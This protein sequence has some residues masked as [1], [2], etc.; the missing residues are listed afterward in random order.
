MATVI[1]RISRDG[2]TVLVYDNGMERNADTGHIIKP[3]PAAMLT[4][5]KS[6][7]LLRKR[8]DNYRREAV[9]RIVGEAAS[10]DPSVSTGAGAFGL[11]AAKQ[12]VALM[13]YD[14]PRIDDLEKLQQLMTGEKSVA[15]TQQNEKIFSGE[16]AASASALMELARR[17]E[18]EIEERVARERAIDIRIENTG[19]DG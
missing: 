13:D 14:K 3:P 17:I 8:W 5:E 7:L 15:P 2:V 12:Y 19:N 10:I 16:I 6:N 4:S 11:V 1:D 9:K 18:T